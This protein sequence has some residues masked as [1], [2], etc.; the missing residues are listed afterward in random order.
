MLDLVKLHIQA[1]DGGFGRVSFRR[2]KFVPKGGP[3]GGDGGDGGNIYIEG[4]K[5]VNTLQHFSGVKEYISESGEPGG[6][7]KQIGHKGEDITLK[8]PI[9]T[10]I[11]LLAENRA[12]QNRRLHREREGSGH[13]NVYH[14]KYYLDKPAGH[15]PF[16]EED[17]LKPVVEIVE[18]NRAKAQEGMEEG[19][20][21]VL[22][23][24]SLKNINVQSLPKLKMLEITEDGQQVLLARGGEGGRGNVTFKGS[25]NT[26]PFE[27][28]YGTFG[29]R[30]LILLEMR[31]L[32]DV[33]LIGYPNAGKSTLLSIVTKANP[34]IANYPFTTIEPN[35]GVMAAPA[36]YERAEGRDIVLADVP[37][38]IEGASQ[39][40]G[41]GFDFLRHINACR[42]LLYV[43]SLE[44]NEIF[45]EGISNEEKAAKLLDQFTVLRKELGEYDKTLLEKPYLISFSKTDLYFPELQTAI[46]NVFEKKLPEKKE[47]LFFSAVTNIGVDDLRQELYKHV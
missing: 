24:E 6:K 13:A 32:A 38:L 36:S 20:E 2:E 45:D 18:A 29:E 37:G 21:M 46:K 40:K 8:V 44:E 14:E 17:D 25:T 34:K 7:Q 31:L 9:G 30:K 15:P 43:L 42:V 22:R 16:R 26:T 3:D 47:L 39:G 10:V 19:A 5:H 11:W 12:S 1:G 35:L 33:G 4:S 23:S 28:E 41:L 27:A